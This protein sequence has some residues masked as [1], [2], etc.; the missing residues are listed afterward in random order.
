MQSFCKINL[1]ILKNIDTLIKIQNYV[2]TFEFSQLRSKSEVVC[3][4]YKEISDNFFEMCFDLLFEYCMWFRHDNMAFSLVSPSV[5]SH[6]YCVM[7]TLDGSD[8]S[9][10]LYGMSLH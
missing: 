7:Y 9:C 3:F 1:D 10:G 5:E 4:C 6:V 8:K 2:H